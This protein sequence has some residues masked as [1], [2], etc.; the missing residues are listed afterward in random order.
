MA[1]GI[2]VQLQKYKH[3]PLSAH[4]MPNAEHQRR[5]EETAEDIADQLMAGSA[6][7]NELH[8]AS[9]KCDV[10]INGTHEAVEVLR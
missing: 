10:H 4:I 7:F 5:G 6:V 9:F 2:W 3:S 8:N 1:K